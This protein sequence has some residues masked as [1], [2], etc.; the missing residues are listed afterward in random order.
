MFHVE[1][2]WVWLRGS[3][4]GGVD[5]AWGPGRSL[6]NESVKEGPGALAYVVAALGVPLDAQD[7]V[8]RGSF[9]GLAAL[10]RFDDTVLW[11]SSGDAKAVSGDADRLVVAGVDGEAKKVVLFRRFG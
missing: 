5:G 6:R 7:K 4:D 9:A 8:R 3:G 10:Y 11:A 1:R 2:R